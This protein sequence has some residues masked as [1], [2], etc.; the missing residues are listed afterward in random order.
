[1]K[2]LTLRLKNKVSVPLN[3]ERITPENLANLSI[4][5]ICKIKILAGKQWVNLGELFNVSGNDTSQIVIEDSI[6]KLERIGRKLA[7]GSMEVIGD[8]GNFVGQEMTGGTLVV[9]GSAG[10]FT[11]SSMR[12]GTLHITGNSGDYLGVELPSRKLGMNGGTVLVEGNTGV[13]AANRMRRGLV[14]VKGDADAGAGADMIAGT[15]VLMGISP[16]DP[17][18]RMR[19]GSIICANQPNFQTGCFFNQGTGN[20]NVLSLFKSELQRLLPYFDCNNFKTHN[21][22]RYVGDRN[23]NGMGELFVLNS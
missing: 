9:H 13:R 7:A 3:M 12:G 6:P 14:V 2:P 17:G 8:A 5:D 19:R 23:N 22:I 11:G 21:S 16:V 20:L 15:L 10:D 1:M 18:V 4:P